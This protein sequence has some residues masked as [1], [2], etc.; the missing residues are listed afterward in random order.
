VFIFF[1]VPVKDVRTVTSFSSGCG[2]C[3]RCRSPDA[4]NQCVS[5]R[6]LA[7]PPVIHILFSTPESAASRLSYPAGTSSQSLHSHLVERLQPRLGPGSFTR[8][9]SLGNE[10]TTRRASLRQQIHG[11]EHYID[12]AVHAC[13]QLHIYIDKPNFSK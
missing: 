1:A 6:R 13:A 12:L 2:S 4:V 5:R 7:P 11:N 10:L 3:G 9:R 8:F